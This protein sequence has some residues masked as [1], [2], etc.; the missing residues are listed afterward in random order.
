MTN[1]YAKRV[2]SP[3]IVFFDSAVGA[4]VGID[5]PAKWAVWKLTKGLSPAFR[6]V[7]ESSDVYCARNFHSPGN[8]KECRREA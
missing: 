7:G 6:V 8:C 2:N 4:P 5:T 1:N 3:E